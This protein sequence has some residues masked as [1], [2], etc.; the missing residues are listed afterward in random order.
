MIVVDQSHA[1]AK[2][3]APARYDRDSHKARTW[4]NKTGVKP[5]SECAAMAGS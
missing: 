1:L 2:P 3:A 4:L 5:V